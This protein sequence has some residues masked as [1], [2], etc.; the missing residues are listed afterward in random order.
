MPDPTSTSDADHGAPVAP[1]R[2]GTLLAHRYRLDALLAR[3]GM[4][5]VWRATDTVLGRDV[6]VKV[7]HPHLADDPAFVDR[8]RTEAV[9][10][11]RLRHPSI[12]A[13]FDTCS[14][15]GAEAIVMELI[16]GVTLRQHLDRHGPLDPTEVAE[17]GA[18]LADALDCAHRAGLVHRDVKPAN[19]LLSDD[20][21]VLLTDFGIAKV[22]DDADRTQTGAMLGSVKYLSPEQVEGE[23]VDPRTDVYSLGIVLYE[24]ATGR[25]PFTGDTPAATA[26]AR[27]HQTPTR[28]RHLRP[29]IPQGLDDVIMRSIR[30]NPAD[31]YTTAA[32]LR[33]AL[34][35]SSPATS[36]HVDADAT[37][38][39][40]VPSPPDRGTDEPRALAA[41]TRRPRWGLGAT[42]VLLVAVALGLAAVL[43][44]RADL[45]DRTSR[46]GTTPTS[47]PASTDAGPLPLVGATAYDPQGSPPPRGENDAQAP[48]AID[49][50]PSTGWSTEG[51]N[52]RDF[53]DHRLKAG[54]GL[55]VDLGSRR[56]IGSVE[57]L[58]ETTDWSAAIYVA[59]RPGADLEDWGAP[60]ATR[61]GLGRQSVLPLD[62]AR[63]RYLL[64]WITDLGAGPSKVRAVLNEVR[65]RP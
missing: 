9:A 41:T 63:G 24:A 36:V 28:P 65:V 56:P 6:A 53:D 51:Y 20:G 14:D 46:E 3:G 1:R 30:R 12:V 19:I 11:A 26:L 62:D 44:S 18:E 5:D 15:P 48:L 55:W 10:A 8:F 59:D 60:V 50:D 34:L 33:L 35:A 38:V 49:G 39:A 22:R 32:D 27:L 17:L 25:V 4:A 16:A 43:L 40:P 45:F 64:V 61:D 54:V 57:L 2:T 31:R 58:S 7:L 23:P 52:T 13:V 37:V 42:A 47:G 29:D 21:R